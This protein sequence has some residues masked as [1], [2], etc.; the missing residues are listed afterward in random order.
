MTVSSPINTEVYT[1]NG[2]TTVFAFPKR[3]YSD[4]HIKVYFDS[5][6]QTTG[7]TVSGVGT[8]SGSVTFTVAPSNGVE[9]LIVREVPYTQETDF[10]NFDGNPSDVTEKQFDLVV[11]QTQ[12]LSESISRSLVAPSGEVGLELELPA[13]SSR[14][15]KFLAFDALGNVTTVTGSTSTGSPF[16]SVGIDLAASDTKAAALSVL[17]VLTD[18]QSPV[19]DW[20]FNGTVGCKG[21]FQWQYDGERTI[22]SNNITSTT[23]TYH[24]FRTQ[25][26]AATDTLDTIST[27]ATGLI[28]LFRPTSAASETIT[29]SHNVS[30]TGKSIYING[31]NDMVLS[32]GYRIVGTIFDSTLDKHV[33]LFDGTTKEYVDAQV[34]TAKVYNSTAVASTSGTSI[35]FT[36]IPSGVKRISVLISGV[37]TNGTSPIIVQIGDSGGVETSG[38]NGA[39]ATDGAS[40]AMTSGYNVTRNTVAANLYYGTLDLYLVD[41]STNTWAANTNVAEPNTGPFVHVGAGTKALSTTL[42]RVRITT[43]GGADTFDAGLINIQYEL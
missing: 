5:V 43:A 16:G 25:A 13:A 1:G 24:I 33:V 22:S 21:K 18:D 20:T 28:T 26:A 31:G 7:Y 35:D 14:A 34:T 23:G 4:S 19:G 11:M 37:S 2:V 32:S 39:I 8:L 38:Y 17:G 29:V 6:L 30:G 41:A 27:N 40:L 42:D 10:E 36:S 15:S 9:V 12:Q 3:F